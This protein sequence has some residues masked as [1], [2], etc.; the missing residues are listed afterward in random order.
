MIRP[1]TVVDIPRIV[2]LGEM[3]HRQS[4]YSRLYF[5]AT[6]V[7]GHMDEL[8]KSPDGVVFVSDRDGYVTG[9]MAGAI[10]EHWF[11]FDKVAFDYMLY[12]HPR[13]RHG[14][15]ACKLIQAFNEWARLQ[16]AGQIRMGITTD[17]NVESTSR[18]YH[19][20]GFVDAGV[21]FKLE[22]DHGD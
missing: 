3:L 16:G 5:S 20:L 8:I 10:M 15:I 7:A 19:A 14:L 4:S 22:L 12:V 13:F 6:K 17:I 11:S 9:V 1:A 2:A 21:L 18:L